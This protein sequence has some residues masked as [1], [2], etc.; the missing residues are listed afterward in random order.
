MAAGPCALIQGDHVS[1][2]DSTEPQRPEPAEPV[3]ASDEQ[4]RRPGKRP[5]LRRRYLAGAGVTMIAVTGVAYGVG[6]PHSYDH[7]KARE[8]RLALTAQDGQAPSPSPSYSMSPSPKPI[9]TVTLGP[10]EPKAEKKQTVPDKVETKGARKPTGPKFST[11]RDVLLLNILTGQCADVPGNDE[12]RPD[13]P[14]V[15][16]TCRKTAEDNQRWDLVVEKKGTGP[17][18][19]DLFTIRNSKD[20]LCIDPPANG[21]PT[22]AR[23]T[24]QHCAQ[25]GGHQVWYMEKKH[26]GQ[27][28]IRS[29]RAGGKCLDVEGAR[30]EDASLTVWPCDPNDDHLWAIEPAT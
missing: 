11:V 26:T 10:N 17:E 8:Q 20:G 12:G 25:G 14:V 16:H 3:D 18:G 27:F 9:P 19:A 21:A 28:W 4:V 2:Q 22:P 7:R 29:T 1:E 13:G 30:A 24:E 23:V 6:L 15:Q 5:R